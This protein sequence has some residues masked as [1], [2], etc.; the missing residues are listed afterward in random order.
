MGILSLNDLDF[1]SVMLPST[2]TKLQK[3]YNFHRNHLKFERGGIRCC[4]RN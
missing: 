4:T 1:I 3:N 2:R